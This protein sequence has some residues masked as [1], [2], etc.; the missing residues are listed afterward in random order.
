MMPF[1]AIPGPASWEVFIHFPI[2]IVLVNI[3]FS[4]ARYDDW[5]H[6]LQHAGRGVIYIITFLGGVFLFLYVGLQIVVPWLFG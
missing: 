1:G 6:I 4:A 5:G 3:L 2:M